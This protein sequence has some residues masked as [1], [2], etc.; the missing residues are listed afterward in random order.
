M[1]LA[2]IN[3]KCEEVNSI[4]QEL[5][6]KR[7]KLQNLKIEEIEKTR[8]VQMLEEIAKLRGEEYQGENEKQELTKAKMEVT[9]CQK[10]VE[11]LEHEIFEGLKN[12]TFPIPLTL[13]KIDSNG[14]SSINFEGSPNN[15]AVKFIASVLNADVPL[16]LDRTELHPDKIIMS[17]VREPIQVVNRLKALRNNISRLAKIVLNEK[18]PDV[19]DVADYL[20]GSNYRQIWEII[21]GRKKI[22]YDDL[23]SEMNL[24]T[25]KEHKKIRNFFTNLE[26][27]LKDKFPFIRLS[28]GVY[29]LTFFG[30]LVWKRYHDK[31]HPKIE[32]VEDL[33]SE[34]A[35]EEPVKRKEAPTLNNYTENEIKD[36]MY[37]KEVKQ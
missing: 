31:Y 34:K 8:E 17:N 22:T 32:L 20:Q 1:E 12:V 37:G 36:I 23:F 13:P 27:S 5:K 30:S 28:P 33:P 25:S 16:E 7:E 35:A 2:E 24:T 9:D 26:N 3:Q 21:R 19:E 11:K 29:E 15:Y 6:A 14:R 4:R 10:R 18:D